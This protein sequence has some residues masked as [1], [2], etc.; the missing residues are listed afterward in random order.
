MRQ[1]FGFLLLFCP[2]EI[3]YMLHNIKKSFILI[4]KCYNYVVYLIKKG[5]VMRFYKSSVGRWFLIFSVVPV[6]IVG[7]VLTLIST[8]AVYKT[9]LEDTK[10]LLRG[11]ALELAYAYQML[12]MD[13]GGIYEED[14]EYYISGIKISD[15]FEVVDRIKEA[16]NV[17]VSLFYKDTRVVT[18]LT[19]AKGKRIVGTKSVEV[20][21]DHVKHG[22]EY[23]ATDI[24]ING[25]EYFGYYV[26]IVLGTGHV[27]GMAFAGISRE[28][29]N[30]AIKTLNRS[31]ITTCVTLC[32][33]FVLLAIFITI[34]LLR[35]QNKAVEYLVEIGN[36]D[37]T[38][39]M[40]PSIYNRTDEYG[41][42]SRNLVKLNDSLYSLILKD[43]LTNLYNRRAAMKELDK[44]L[45]A[46]NQI[47]AETFTLAIA[48]IDHFKNVNDTY[49][50]NCGDI[51]LKEVA[52]ILN[53]IP[54]ETGFSARW[55]GEEFIIVLKGRLQDNIS[56]I[57]ELA[58]NI[59]ACHVEY[60][61]Q[62][63]S[64]TMTFGVSE[65]KAP[66]KLE[67]LISRADR[68]LYEGKEA[69]RNRIVS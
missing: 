62:D 23:F 2:N 67:Q 1:Y 58:D 50:H 21:E 43:A 18:T 68:L 56:V 28:E 32:C 47:D 34:Y 4:S 48:D 30:D 24:N 16:A 53:T 45:A 15:E 40:D 3:G 13:D 25:V 42:I 26:P 20:W 17:D 10:A 55:G 41:I 54:E 51:V 36:G 22:E 6:V 64:V 35:I 11:N 52:D 19:D 59:R 65:Y 8:N 27:E 7:I 69:G 5:E 33:I 39:K 38:H 31:A 63:V 9:K 14:G 61:T 60:D 44:Y 12:D 66:E 57:E 46:A 29:I 49:G 37:Y